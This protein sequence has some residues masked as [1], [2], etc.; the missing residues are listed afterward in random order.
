M[1][2]TFNYSDRTINFIN[3]STTKYYFVHELSFY[4]KPTMSRGETVEF[5]CESTIWCRWCRRE[6]RR[7]C[8]YYYYYR[9]LFQ[10]VIMRRG[11]MQT[12]FKGV[13]FSHWKGTLNYV[14][15][16]DQGWAFYAC[17]TVPRN[18]KCVGI[19]CLVTISLHRSPFRTLP[20][21]ERRGVYRLHSECESPNG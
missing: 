3:D 4:G 6:R 17:Q 8:Y 18:P 7:C 14:S 2:S 13:F 16:K 5:L 20:P 12:R 15:G 11:P 19:K 10:S 21:G 1:Y 9:V